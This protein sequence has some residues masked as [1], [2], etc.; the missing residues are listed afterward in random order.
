MRLSPLALTIILALLTGA[1][2]IGVSALLSD[3]FSPPGTPT[4]ELNNTTATNLTDYRSM[5]RYMPMPPNGWA[6]NNSTGG[7]F[8]E[9]PDIFSFARTNYLK[10]GTNATASVV[11][12]DSG[13]GDIMWNSIFDNGFIYDNDEGYAKV[14]AYKGM[15]AWTTARYGLAGNAYSLYLKLDDRYGVAILL[16]NAT[17]SSPVMEF[18]DRINVHNIKAL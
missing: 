14:F 10:P 18:A 8:T 7:V 4:V 3:H 13:G 12:Y 16:R 17:D 6:V 2:A 5:A 9:K 1:V 15:P 11:I